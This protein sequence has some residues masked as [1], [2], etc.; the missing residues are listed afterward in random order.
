LGREEYGLLS[1][2]MEGREGDVHGEGQEY[3]KLEGC[4]DVRE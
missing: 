4:R 1:V 3:G 2:K